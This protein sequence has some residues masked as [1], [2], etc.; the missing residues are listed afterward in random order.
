MKILIVDDSK[1]HREAARTQLEA[2]GHEVVVMSGYTDLLRGGSILKEKSFDV[3]LI[4]LLMPAESM[5]LGEKGM[6]H[7]GHE[8][9]VGF[10]LSIFLAMSGVPRVAVVT[11]TNHH[12]HP[13]SAIMD[14]FLCGP[15]TVSGA[16]VM[17]LH[18]HLTAESSKDWAAAL[19]EVLR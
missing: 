12:D 8:M 17:Y 6:E 18:A 5:T 16:S 14:S 19:E 10:P 1:K 13:A 2:L 3:A 9:M 11:D 7:F 4:D 15:L